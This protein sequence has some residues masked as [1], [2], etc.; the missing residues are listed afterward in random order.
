MKK[1]FSLEDKQKALKLL[2]EKGASYTAKKYKISRITLYRWR[3][4]VWKD[5][6]FSN[7]VH[8]KK[9][10]DKPVSEVHKESVKKEFVEQLK[11]AIF[12]LEKVI[13]IFSKK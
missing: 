13:A 5:K 8:T 10:K 2:K 7:D 12:I 3:N 4:T 1:P 9:E 11:T 6:V